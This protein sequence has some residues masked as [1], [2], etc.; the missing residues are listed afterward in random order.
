MA[1][2]ALKSQRLIGG[3]LIVYAIAVTF[4]ASDLHSF[5][6]TTSFFLLLYGISGYIT[7]LLGSMI[8]Y[9]LLR[10]A[11]HYMCQRW[12]FSPVLSAML[13]SL[14]VIVLP[15]LFLSILLINRISYYADNTGEIM[16]GSGLDFFGAGSAYRTQHVGAGL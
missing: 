6:M 10:P 11:F 9:V 3:D 13:L 15:F 12:H 4:Y 14:V 16:H 8:L 7:A 5:L 2:I 1:N